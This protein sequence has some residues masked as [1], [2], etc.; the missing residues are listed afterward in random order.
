MDLTAKSVEEKLLPLLVCKE[1][2]NNTKLQNMKDK[3]QP[4]Y[5]FH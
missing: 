4:C 1:T 2:P 3:R 5:R